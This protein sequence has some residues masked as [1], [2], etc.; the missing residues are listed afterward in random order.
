MLGRIIRSL[1]GG[2]RRSVSRGTNPKA[3]AA[4]TAARTVSKKL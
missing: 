4:K 2:R 1:L 3:Q